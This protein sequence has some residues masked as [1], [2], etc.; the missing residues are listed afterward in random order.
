MNWLQA[1]QRLAQKDADARRAAL[2]AL[3]QEARLTYTVQ[4]GKPDAKKLTEAKNY[5]VKLGEAVAPCLLFCAHYDAAPGSFGANDNAA[6]VCVLL[7]LA[8]TLAQRGETVEFAFFDGEETGR[9]GS[10]VYVRELARE[11]VTGVVNVDLC[12]YGDTVVL[13]GN[14]RTQKP[15]LARFLRK[16]LLAAHGAQRVKYLPDSDDV[17]FRTAQL[18]VLSAAVVPRWDVSYLDTLA[19]YGGGLLGRPPE[20]EMITGQMEVSTTMH[21]GF[22]DTPEHVQPEAMQ[23]MYDYLLAAFDA[24]AQ[25]KRGWGRRA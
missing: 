16:T 10:R 20:F 7:A 18:P 15:P 9:A 1:V 5:L 24:P 12:G 23:R 11:T 6:A 19:T 2:E 4:T 17:S 13:L 14:S 8:R 25:E 21:G 3:L 22:R